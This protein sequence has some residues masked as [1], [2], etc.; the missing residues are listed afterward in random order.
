[1]LWSAPRSRS[2]AFFR[3]MAQRGDF[4][5]VHEPFSYL[6]E[7]GYAEVGGV[8]VFSAAELLGALRSA[9]VVRPVFAKETT[10]KRYPEVLGDAGFLG[11]DARH[12]FLIR[13]PRET[14]ASYHALSPSAPREKIGFESL[15]EVFCS[16]ARLTG[17][18]PLV[19]DAADLV[20]S[21]AAVVAAYCAWAGI[22]YLPEALTWSPGG[23]PE[24]ELSQQWHRDVA[25]SSGLGSVAA[26]G[27][28]DVDG[29]PVLSAYL[30]YHLPYYE[31]LHARRLLLLSRRCY[32]AG[33]TTRNSWAT[34][35]VS[36]STVNPGSSS[37]SRDWPECQKVSCPARHSATDVYPSPSATACARS[38]SASRS[39]R[40]ATVS[41]TVTGR[42]AES[43]TTCRSPG[44]G[45]GSPSCS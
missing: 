8:R 35:S 27:S 42:P 43:I 39:T 38:M 40:T 6:A 24:W 37:A 18:G 33:P 7:F 5:V 19:I 29:D 11:P 9:A 41:I 26:G 10:G 17:A 34:T 14:I 32:R 44:R 3:M 12:A 13:H 4:T 36:S 23:L 30:D 28:V 45:S 25:A 22:S 15:H 16:V 31:A 1:M 21:P 20:R 2:T